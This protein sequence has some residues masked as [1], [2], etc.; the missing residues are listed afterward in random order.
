MNEDPTNTSLR[1]SVY[2]KQSANWPGGWCLFPFNGKCPKCHYDL[3]ANLAY[4]KLV[5]ERVTGC[6]KCN[7]S[8]VE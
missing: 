7:H 2:N 1:A 5:N 6:P 8:F 4:D 3:I